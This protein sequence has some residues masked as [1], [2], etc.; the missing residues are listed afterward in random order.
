MTKPTMLNITQAKRNIYRIVD[1]IIKDDE[2][3]KHLLKITS[4]DFRTYTHSVTVGI[5]GIS[6]SKVLFQGSD[7][8]DLHEI[9]V[10]FFLHDIGKVN[11]D[12]AIINKPG[13]L[14][15][16]EMA[17]IRK[18]PEYGYQVLE[19]TN[20]LTEQCKHI[21]LEHHE[22]FDGT[23]YPNKL[24]GVSINLYG[25]ICSIADVYEALTALRPYKD[26]V[27]PFGALKIMKDEM[28]QH[29]HRPLFEKF[30][31]LLVDR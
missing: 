28:M 19:E 31:N 11:I 18:H 20:Q 3:A 7:A 8:H 16:D 21:V 15:E 4:H 1:F 10:G 13:K 9:G 24:K 22:R 5:L 6:L 23:G 26:Q 12:H 17:V 2:I 30:A 27:T 29:F 25:R 14:T